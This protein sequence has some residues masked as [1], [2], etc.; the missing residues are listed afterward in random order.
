MFKRP[1]RLASQLVAKRRDGSM[2]ML[3]APITSRPPMIW[4]SLGTVSAMVRSA[5]PALMPVPATSACYLLIELHL[6]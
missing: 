1:H 5:T 4:T 2:A 6:P 3:T